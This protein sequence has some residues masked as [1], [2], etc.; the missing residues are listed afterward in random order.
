MTQVQ[1]YGQRVGARAHLLI[2]EASGVADLIASGPLERI[3][4]FNGKVVAGT[5]PGKAGED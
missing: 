1:A 5:L 4:L 2:T 3:V